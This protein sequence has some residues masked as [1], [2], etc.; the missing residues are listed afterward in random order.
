MRL[1]I[2]QIHSQ[3]HSSHRQEGHRATSMSID[4][5]VDRTLF[6]VITNAIVDND[7]EAVQQSL[8]DG[9]N[10]NAFVH[11]SN[12]PLMNA[13]IH[14]RAAIVRCLLD[15]GACTQMRSSFGGTAATIAARR[16]QLEIV[17]MLIQH[18]RVLL[19]KKASST[20]ETP[21]MA[22]SAR[23]CGH[24]EICRF[25]V[26]SG[27]NVNAQDCNGKTALVIAVSNR[28]LDVVRLLLA[29]GCNVEVGD[30]ENRTAIYWAATGGSIDVLRELFLHSATMCLIDKHGWT[31]F[32]LTHY[33]KRDKVPEFLIQS[34]SD[35]FLSQQD[36]VGRLAVHA[37]LRTAEYTF[38]EFPAFFPPLHLLQVK[39]Q[40]GKLLWNHFR[41]L[42]LSVDE[43]LCIRDDS[44]KLPIHV[45]CQT[46]APVEVLAALVN[47]DSATL[48]M[49]DHAG[50][51]PLHEYCCGY[52]TS[53]C[54]SA[55]RY[56]VER[57]GVG[58]LAARNREGAVPLHVLCGAS[59][60]ATRPPLLAIQYMIQ[61]F[62]GSLGM[63]T[64]AGMYPFMIAAR[65]ASMGALS[66]VYEIVRA[67]PTLAIPR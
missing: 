4:D 47:R 27:C 30:D 65:N 13:C 36:E 64:N 51:L 43:E 28:H 61:S 20:G 19:N 2:D 56:L 33:W 52:T 55:L 38:A 24:M 18:D 58:T 31:P 9:A 40:S 53:V 67:N 14:N 46:N 6:T 39:I 63:R 66:V 5:N 25:L 17:K 7:C 23:R 32:A 35:R 59:M 62:P 11:G 12:P 22:A 15:A 54:T 37:L 44:G 21:L 8:L 48:H 41:A 1:F 3:H 34:Y 49:A 26:E 57:G 42:L 29:A 10:V 50:A 16:N 45:A 60:T